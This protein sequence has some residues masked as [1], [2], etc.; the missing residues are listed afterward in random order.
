MGFCCSSN[1]VAPESDFQDVVV[2]VNG[3]DLEQQDEEFR[4]KIELEEEEKKLEETLEF[5]RRIENEA[6]QKHLAEQQKKSSGTYLE[7]VVD[8][9]QDVQLK[10]VADGPDVHENLRPL[11]QVK[12][13]FAVLIL[14]IRGQ[15]FIIVVKLLLHV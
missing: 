14:Y 9:L 15:N 12:I 7:E 1:P 3:D 11:M 5:Q 10:A 13:S 8:K 4:R 2:T 6:K